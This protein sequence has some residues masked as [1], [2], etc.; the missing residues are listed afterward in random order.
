MTFADQKEGY[1]RRDEEARNKPSLSCEIFC[2]NFC[3]D[4]RRVMLI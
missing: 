3:N 4:A 1:I 2:F